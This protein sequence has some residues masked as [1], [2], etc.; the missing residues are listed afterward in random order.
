MSKKGR[1]KLKVMPPKRVKNIKKDEPLNIF[2][3]VCE[4]K[5]NEESIPLTSPESRTISA[6]EEPSFVEVSRSTEGDLVLGLVYYIGMNSSV[7]AGYQPN[8]LESG[9]QS[10]VTNLNNS[11]KGNETVPD[12]EWLARVFEYA[13]PEL[14]LDYTHYHPNNRPKW[15]EIFPPEI[16]LNLTFK[17]L[18]RV[19]FSFLNPFI[20]ATEFAFD[21]NPSGHA[22]EDYLSFGDTPGLIKL[23]LE[24]LNLIKHKFNIISKA[25]KGHGIT[26]S[27]PTID[28][29]RN[30]FSNH[31]CNMPAVQIK[32]AYPGSMYLGV[33]VV[34]NNGGNI[35]SD[36]TG[37]IIQSSTVEGSGVTMHEWGHSTGLAHPFSGG[38]RAKLTN[39]GLSY[40]NNP[41]ITNKVDFLNYPLYPPFIYPNMPTEDGGTETLNFE[42]LNEDET[43]FVEYLY[44]DHPAD[45]TNNYTRKIT[46]EDGDEQD[47]A[48]FYTTGDSPMVGYTDLGDVA[49]F[50]GG[51]YIEEAGKYHYVVN[52]TMVDEAGR[53]VRKG[54]DVTSYIPFCTGVNTYVGPGLGTDGTAFEFL[55][56]KFDPFFMANGNQTNPDF[57][58]YPDNT[59]VEDLFNEEFCPCLYTPQTFISEGET[60]TYTILG[61]NSNLNDE[62]SIIDFLQGV[63][64]VDFNQ[65]SAIKTLKN[66][67][68]EAKSKNGFMHAVGTYPDFMYICNW[69]GYSGF[70]ANSILPRHFDANNSKFVTPDESL[71]TDSLLENDGFRPRG[72]AV[73]GS[74]STGNGPWFNRYRKGSSDKDN[75]LYNPFK[76]DYST[77]DGNDFSFL[78]AFEPQKGQMFGDFTL[79]EMFD[80]MNYSASPYHLGYT[81][82][83]PVNIEKFNACLYSYIQKFR[84]PREFASEIDLVNDT[85]SGSNEVQAHIDSLLTYVENYNTDGVVFGCMDPDAYNYNPEATHI[86]E[87]VEKTYYC[88]DS[89]ALN[90]SPFNT[91]TSNT[92][93]N[94][95]CEYPYSAPPHPVLPIPVCHGDTNLNGYP[96]VVYC[97][98]T[99]PFYASV[100]ES[101]ATTSGPGSS[102][103]L[104][105]HLEEFVYDWIV[106]NNWDH[107]SYSSGER[108]KYD[109]PE[110][111][112]VPEDGS[113]GCIRV[114]LIGSTQFCF[115]PSVQ[116]GGCSLVEGG[117]AEV[118]SS[119]FVLII[120]NF[121]NLNTGSSVEY[122]C[123]SSDFLEGYPTHD[124]LTNAAYYNPEYN[125]N[126]VAGDVRDINISEVASPFTLGVQRMI[127]EILYDIDGNVYIGEVITKGNNVYGVGATGRIALYL[128]NDLLVKNIVPLLPHEIKAQ[129]F[130][131]MK[132]KIIN[133][134]KF[135]NIE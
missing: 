40:R 125:L 78:E 8:N 116:G 12:S 68:I 87:C 98:Y 47:E 42:I 95:L 96:D 120:N 60:H 26:E 65:N 31:F 35:H 107:S 43:R 48:Y 1:K 126:L 97:N 32:S 108:Y 86:N 58:Q 109:C 44:K 37:T 113:G 64:Y 45:R 36:Y 89:D 9:I 20:R 55:Y 41:I 30:K 18:T 22:D 59:K 24:R 102:I 19:R 93:D 39:E 118:S 21:F 91:T 132:K 103:A 28:L 14:D 46:F 101:G 84:I 76:I 124:V 122:G 10:A 73:L 27:A 135:A 105:N 63:S 29:S 104:N 77:G 15:N 33:M 119:A 11:I 114:K 69:V 111:P 123:P 72:N 38:G 83:S 23:D 85:S 52:P 121:N 53:T 100:N 62:G 71:W 4:N 82:N 7:Q 131:R 92:I 110:N 117:Q 17:L 25:E 49:T 2:N 79:G 50:W 88:S 90:Y 127:F 67:L 5:E 134:L 66:F 70:R 80:N 115:H 16:F 6:I 112:I 94:T 99:D 51:S 106:N 74:G 57:P 56:N 133:L 61:D 34:A 3:H 54:P 81:M 13:F 75:S 129:E 128:R 130:E